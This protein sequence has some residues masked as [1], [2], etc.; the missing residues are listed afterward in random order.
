MRELLSRWHRER[1]GRWSSGRYLLDRPA[2]EGCR[3]RRSAAGR[4]VVRVGPKERVRSADDALLAP[5]TH[6][7]EQVQRDLGARMRPQTYGSAISGPIQLS[8]AV[9]CMD[10]QYPIRHPS[11]NDPARFSMPCLWMRNVS[12]GGDPAAGRFS[13]RDQLLRMRRVQRHVR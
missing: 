8:N 1:P 3:T 9:Y 12:L 11:G 6:A 10:I 2:A 13:I 5:P 4:S 7:A